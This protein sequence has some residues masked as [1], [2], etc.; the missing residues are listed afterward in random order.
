M[1][2][3]SGEQTTV[4]GR[5]QAKWGLTWWRVIAVLLAFSLAGSTTV[6]LKTPVTGLVL[7]PDTPQWQQWLVYLVVMVPL[8]QVLLLGYGTLLGQYAFFRS[9]WRA[10][11]S[12]LSRH[13]P[14]A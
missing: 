6:L 7:A 9:R 4:L 8:Y 10:V 14:E 2:A 11:T 12:R 13:G 1:A 5:L 3:S